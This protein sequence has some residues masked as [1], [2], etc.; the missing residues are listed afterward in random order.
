MMMFF[1]LFDDTNTDPIL[2]QR[3]SE[4]ETSRSRSNLDGKLCEAFRRD[5]FGTHDQNVR[6][7]RHDETR[8]RSSMRDGFLRRCRGEYTAC[9][10]V[11]LIFID[12]FADEVVPRRLSLRL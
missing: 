9:L 6:V 8:K 4:N 10:P 7:N 1:I 11:S 3:K 12:F 2:K 5:V